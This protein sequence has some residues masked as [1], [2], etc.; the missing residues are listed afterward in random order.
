[1]R[2][3]QYTLKSSGVYARCRSLI[4]EHLQ[5]KDFKRSVPAALLAGL[6]LLAAFTHS[7]LCM[8][9]RLHPQAPSYQSVRS[10]LYALLPK[11]SRTLLSR[12]LAALWASLPAHLRA[13]PQAMALDM[14]QRP[15]HGRKNAK[16]VTRR[17]KKASTRKSFTYAT[18]AVISPLG[19]WTIGLLPTYPTMRLETMIRRLLAQ[20]SDAG[21]PI[22]YLMADKEFYSAEVVTMLQQAGVPFLIPVQERG[23]KEG[24]GNKHLFEE[25]TKPGWYEYAWETK[26][27]KWVFAEGQPGKRVSRG[28]LQARVDV[29]VARGKEKKGKERR[30]VYACWGLTSWSPAQVREAYRKRFGIEASY[31]QLGQCLGRTS[32][33]NEGWR[34]LLVGLGLLLL[35]VW[36]TVHSEA[37]GKGPLGGRD[38]SLGRLRLL[39]LLV[40]M[41]VAVLADRPP[42]WWWKTQ[43]PVPEYFAADP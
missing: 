1:M 6:L 37:M 30:L 16:G 28:K 41:L 43:M 23:K 34:L 11:S 42:D 40:G 31:R 2:Q 20:A 21:I 5:V 13:T 35:N 27:R 32:S 38:L 19:R 12:V 25:A 26:R 33:T 29:C 36:A 15:F 9:C 8:A 17:Q 24:A 39:E 18:L 4:T 14:H 7:S 10:A 3:K 22:C